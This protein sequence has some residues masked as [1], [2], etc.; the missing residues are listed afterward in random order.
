MA[1]VFVAYLAA[2]VL[3]SVGLALRYR[4]SDPVERLQIRWVAAN[5]LAIL[6]AVP[7]LIINPFGLGD[8]AWLVWLLATAFVPFSVAVAI[9]RYHLYDIDRVISN[10]IGYGLVSIVLFAIF[11]AVNL[12]LVS[13]VSPFV[14]DEA[15]AVAASTLLVA[16]LFNP[17]RGR[18]QRLVDRRFHR[19]HYDAE[20]MVVDFAAR[21]RDELDLPTLASELAATTIRAVQPTTAGIWLRTGRASR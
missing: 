15:I 17:V 5:G 16:A 8:G 14:K 20:R 4:R 3:A 21:L 13:N 1:F 11:G 19:A 10:A 2:L 6:A 12:A 9:L 7:V 18:I